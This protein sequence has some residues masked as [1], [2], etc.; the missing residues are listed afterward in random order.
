[1]RFLIVFIGAVSLAVVTA[2]SARATTSGCDRTAS[3]ERGTVVSTVETTYDKQGNPTMSDH[4]LDTVERGPLYI[5]V[6]KTRLDYQSF[7]FRIAA[8]SFFG[9]NCSGAAGESVARDAMLDLPS[10]RASVR[11]G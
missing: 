11:T 4:A 5:A 9:L 2:P 6:T 3:V 1:M 8:G 7:E 10:G